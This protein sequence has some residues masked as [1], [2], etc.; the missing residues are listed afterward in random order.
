[1]KSILLIDLA[2]DKLGGAERVINTLA[3]ALSVSYHV[4]VCSVYKYSEKPFYQYPENVKRSYLIDLSKLPSTKSKSAVSFVFFRSFEKTVEMTFYNK[5][6]KKYCNTELGK[7]DV[8]I[9]GRT[10]AAVDFL[11]HMENYKGKVI[12]RDATHLYDTFKRNQMLM[13][14]YFPERVDV[15]IV[16]SDESINA[17]KDFFENDKLKIE[18]IYN[19][20]GITPRIANSME[21]KQITG[22][23]RYIVEKGFENLIEAF[24]IVHR[25]YP[26]W[27]LV[28]LGT[29]RRLKKYQK[30]CKKL[31]IVQSVEF[32]KSDDIVEDYYKTGIYVTTSRNEGYA[33]SLVEALACGVP[34]ISFDWY[35]GVED[36][37]KDEQTGCIVRLQ[38]R[39]KHHDAI[40]DK[41]NIENLAAKIMYLIENPGVRERLS[42][43]AVGIRKTRQLEKIIHKWITLIEE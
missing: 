23:G 33:N 1:M 11:P 13:K 25:K 8:V 39:K 22:V 30:L 31:D 35:M 14:R 43:N 6:I 37:I 36:I 21:S 7:Y 40:D 4:D 17:Y 12:V 38:D 32:R 34:S 28:L 9:F 41:V 2:I 5:T 15:F 3:N 19:P 26:D 29:G 42:K 24:A 16:S 18:K 10:M 20:L 27:R